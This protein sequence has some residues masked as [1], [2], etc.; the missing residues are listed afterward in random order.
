MKH[1]VYKVKLTYDFS[2]GLNQYPKGSFY[3]KGDNFN[4]SSNRIKFSETGGVVYDTFTKAV[5]CRDRID[6][7]FED[8]DMLI[9]G[10]SVAIETFELVVD[11][12]A[13]YDIPVSDHIKQLWRDTLFLVQHLLDENDMR[14][15]DM[16]ME[17]IDIF[18]YRPSQLLGL[19]KL[20]KDYNL[21]YRDTFFH[22]VK[23]HMSKGYND[24]SEIDEYMGEF[25]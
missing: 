5:N 25:L 6:S 15:V 8:V 1:N 18:S 21:V 23:Y 4:N 2:D 13:H 10:G 16:L 9:N 11:Q 17:R 14:S 12:G 19:L 20:T 24:T 7:A 3:V 22:K